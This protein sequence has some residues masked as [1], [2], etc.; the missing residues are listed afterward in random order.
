MKITCNKG[1][2][3]VLFLNLINLWEPMQYLVELL[4]YLN[5]IKIKS[6]PIIKIIIHLSFQWMVKILIV[7]IEISLLDNNRAL[8]NRCLDFN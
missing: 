7:T 8:L 6:N 2:P 1:V 4:N 5:Q 3:K